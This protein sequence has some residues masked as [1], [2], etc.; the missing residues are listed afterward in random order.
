MAFQQ[1][2]GRDTETKSITMHRV[3]G[4]FLTPK[5]LAAFS[6]LSNNH[7]GCNKHAGW[8]N[9]Q[10]LGDFK[11]QIVFKTHLRLFLMTKQDNND[12]NYHISSKWQRSN[13]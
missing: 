6:S 4:V 8:K 5:F 13:T 7:A 9:L 11:N 1:R 2:S 12:Q 3:L 10:N